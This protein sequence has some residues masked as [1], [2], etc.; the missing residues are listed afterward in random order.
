MA[1]ISKAIWCMLL[2][3]FLFPTT[4]SAQTREGNV[5][6]ADSRG[7][8]AWLA[9]PAH[10]DQPSYYEVV[11]EYTDS[12]TRKMHTRYIGGG[13]TQVERS[14]VNKHLGV[15]GN[16]AFSLAFQKWMTGKQVTIRIYGYDW[17]SNEWYEVQ[18]LSGQPGH[19]I[20]RSEDD[21][22][23]SVR[24]KLI[25]RR[26]DNF[27][28]FLGS[29]VQVTLLRMTEHGY[30][31][32]E[33]SQDEV[34]GNCAV[35]KNVFSCWEG[36]GEGRTLLSGDYRLEVLASGMQILSLPFR[37][38][39]GEL[40]FGD[41]VLTPLAEMTITQTVVLARQVKITVE[42]EQWEGQSIEVCGAVRSRGIN[43]YDA[44]VP[45]GCQVA[46]Q[47]KHRYEFSLM[48]PDE[49]PAGLW[50]SYKFT[51]QPAG[52]GWKVIGEMWGNALIER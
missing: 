34:T 52:N 3:L 49:F 20:V 37:Y 43:T 10:P 51:I 27:D 45:L 15:T 23:G 50:V 24:G 12:T 1:K 47:G 35:Q 32:Y 48:V 30:L 21:R 33:S 2:V 25:T 13:L 46:R 19:S 5:D 17:N 4:V 6:I 14:D 28:S 36:W 42:A 18:Y 22:R 31:T 11:G 39:G 26:A 41:V 44:N 9:N 16:H 7:I 38:N 29:Y 40:N 8:H